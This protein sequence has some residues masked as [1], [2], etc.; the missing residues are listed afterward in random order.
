MTRAGPS[1]RQSGHDASKCI[2]YESVGQAALQSVERT[3]SHNHSCDS[4]V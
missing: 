4:G 2:Q 1:T 3:A